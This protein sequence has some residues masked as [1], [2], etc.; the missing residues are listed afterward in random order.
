MA[1][2]RR[3]PRKWFDVMWSDLAAEQ[4]QMA[5]SEE[6]TS[7]RMETRK[8]FAQLGSKSL[9]IPPPLSLQTFKVYTYP[10]A[11]VH[12]WSGAGTGLISESG[13]HGAWELHV[14]CG[15]DDAMEK[16]TRC[17]KLWWQV[18]PLRRELFAECSGAE[19]EKS[20]F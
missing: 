14:S 20:S 9:V 19:V 17:Q 10:C 5:G 8:S 12:V 6:F 1:G 2:G 4:S 16:G 13:P 15:C 18:T 3:R 7:R 11:S